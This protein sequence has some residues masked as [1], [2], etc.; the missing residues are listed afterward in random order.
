[1]TSLTHRLEFLGFVEDT[2]EMT[3]SLPE[4]KV[5]AI[6]K[7]ISL[8]LSVEMVQI[9]KLAD[10]IG[11]LIATKAVVHT[12]PLHFPLEDHLPAQVAV[13]SSQSA[14]FPRDSSQLAVVEGSPSK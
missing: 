13:L 1:V 3:I 7:E 12:A 5:N 6:Q 11:M 10:V 14:A 8:L 4:P 9:R 2:R